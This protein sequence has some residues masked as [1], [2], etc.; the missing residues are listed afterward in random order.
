MR[1]SV[2]V[3]PVRNLVSSRWKGYHLLSF[4]YGDGRMDVI[5]QSQ[6]EQLAREMAN[7]ATT[8]ENLNGLMRTIMKTAPKQMLSIEL[9]GLNPNGKSA[10]KLVYLTISEASKKCQQ[11]AY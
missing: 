7:Q 6:A 2:F 1:Q 9:D 4:F 3:G 11:V 8:L 10:L 5:L